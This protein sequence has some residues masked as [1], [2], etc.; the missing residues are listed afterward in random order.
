ME[1]RRHPFMFYRGRS[2]WAP[3]WVWKQGTK[4]KEIPPRVEIGIL[5]QVWRARVKPEA[6]F[7]L[8][9]HEANEYMGCLLFDNREVCQRVHELL[10]QHLGNRIEDI[11][12]LDVNS[13]L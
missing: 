11:G 8:I 2:N 7:L 3:V 1:L 13:M 6:L 4:K 5:R 12:S 9:E 10:R